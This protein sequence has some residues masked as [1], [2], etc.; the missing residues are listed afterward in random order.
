MSL[1][2]TV[3]LPKKLDTFWPAGRFTAGWFLFFVLLLN[4]LNTILS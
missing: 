3:P 4:K 2:D 1:I